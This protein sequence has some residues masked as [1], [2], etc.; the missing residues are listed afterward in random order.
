MIDIFLHVKGEDQGI[1]H[2]I[3]LNILEFKQL[4]VQSSHTDII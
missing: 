4:L 2:C 3:A 1:L